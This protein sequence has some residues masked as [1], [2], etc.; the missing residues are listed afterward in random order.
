[1]ADAALPLTGHPVTGRIV[2]K[3]FKA[4][5][6]ISKIES[7]EFQIVTSGIFLIHHPLYTMSKQFWENA[8][9][10]TLH[11]TPRDQAISLGA[12]MVILRNYTA[13]SAAKLVTRKKLPHTLP[14]S[15]SCVAAAAASGWMFR[16]WWLLDSYDRGCVWKHYGWFCGLMCIGCCSG[17]VSYA[18][19]AQ[20][21]AGLY[22]SLSDQS[23]QS[24]LSYAT[25]S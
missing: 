6:T 13:A 10:A 5:D 19:W 23:K 7:L 22:A 20:W 4:E 12:V 21:L 3:A 25:V 9:K 11:E 14:Q 17:A 18:A 15:A 1:L 8:C 2:D 24:I 16:R